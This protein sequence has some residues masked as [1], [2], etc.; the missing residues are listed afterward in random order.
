VTA[1]EDGGVAFLWP[2]MLLALLGVPLLVVGYRR[3]LAA[4]ERRRAALAAAGF[5]AAP[6]PRGRHAA[7]VL[8]LAALALL[9]LALARPQASVPDPQRSGTVIVAVDVSG[10]MAAADAPGTPTRLD[11]AKAAAKDLVAAQPSTVRLGVVAIGG[12]V[13]VTQ[14]P[15]DDRA[16]VTAAIDR[17]VPEGGTDLARGLRTALGAAIGAPVPV[18]PAP[19]GGVDPVGP[20]LGYHGSSAIVLLSDGE[21]T[22][23]PDPLEVADLASTAGVRIYPVGIGRAGGTVLQIDGFQV[24]T[25]LDEPLLREIAARTDGTYLPAVDPAALAD[26]FDGVELGWTVRAR[27]IELTGALAAA[28]GLLVLAGVA[29][30]LA[31]TGR[32]V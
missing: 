23:E 26:V 24:A 18:D 11:A 8:L 3:L 7:P 14:E 32:V 10:S 2:W 13:A 4:G 28:A 31:R 12:A 5:S 6:A 29:L 15:T 16:A 20:D 9:L 1:P 17:L 19:A 27:T 21:N 25:A 30:S 22:G